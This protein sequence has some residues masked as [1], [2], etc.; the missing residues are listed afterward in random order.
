MR[1]K[2]TK[3]ALDNVKTA[4]MRREGYYVPPGRPDNVKYEVA[5]NIGVPLNDQYNGDLRTRDAGRV[6]GPI[7]GQ[8]VREMIRLAEQELAQRSR[9]K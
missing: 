7:G 2:E 5:Q 1:S 4:V 6:G 9:N 8:M 3:R